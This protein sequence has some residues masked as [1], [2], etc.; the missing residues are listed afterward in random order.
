MG[1]LR[2]DKQP[3]AEPPA[4]HAIG[5]VRRA[6]ARPP[7][8]GWARVESELALDPELAAALAGL[9]GYSHV[10]VLFALHTVGDDGR[11]VV[12]QHPAGAPAPTG[13]FALRTQARPNP[14]G[15]TAVELL[16]VDGGTLRVRGLD[17]LDGTPVLDIKPYIPYYDCVADARVPAWIGHP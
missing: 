16:R 14:I 4:F 8:E 1:W 3:G 17:A 6:P 12:T 2:G 13:V 11:Q 10:W 9:D 7:A 5:H 15:M